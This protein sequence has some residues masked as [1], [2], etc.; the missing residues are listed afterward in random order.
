MKRSIILDKYAFFVCIVFISGT[1]AGCCHRSC[2]LVGPEQVHINLNGFMQHV[3]D[4]D[5]VVLTNS[6]ECPGI[7]LFIS[8]REL[9]NLLGAV[10]N[11]TPVPPSGDAC[12]WQMQFYSKH[13]LLGIVKFQDDCIRY[14]GDYLD[15]SGTCVG[16]Y[17]KML[18]NMIRLDHEK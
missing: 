16:L 9:T 15:Q 8:G 2:S 6:I 13:R 4:A 12:L 17:R 5:H 18:M 11:A 10:S 1:I 14:H 3:Q 7:S